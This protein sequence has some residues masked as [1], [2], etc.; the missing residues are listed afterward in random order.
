MPNLLSSF[1]ALIT[2]YLRPTDHSRFLPSLFDKQDGQACPSQDFHRQYLHCLGDAL[3]MAKKTAGSELPPLARCR[4]CRVALIKRPSLAQHEYILIYITIDGAPWADQPSRV[5][6]LVCERARAVP[7]GSFSSESIRQKLSESSRPSGAP[8]PRALD[9]YVFYEPDSNVGPADDP[10][11]NHD[12]EPACAPPLTLLFAV[13]DVIHDDSQY[14]DLILT[15]QCCSF[16]MLLYRALIKQRAA[17]VEALPLMRDEHPIVME[18]DDTAT[19]LSMYAGAVSGD[20]IEKHHARLEASFTQAFAAWQAK[21]QYREDIWKE[22][23]AKD[24]ELAA[25]DEELVAKDEELAAKDEEL[26]AIEEELAAIE[27]E[28]AAIEEEK[29]RMRA[30]VAA[31]QM[32]GSNAG[33]TAES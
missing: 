15:Q 19:G 3:H 16:A 8:A 32:A 25:K 5:G 21:A 18:D 27:E 17:E 30:T 33:T 24:E 31:M 12:F 9:R 1:Q 29:S 10:A 26:A 4:I 14:C 7:E 11:Y 20:D 6:K 28:L 22:F 13:V 23:V 2:R